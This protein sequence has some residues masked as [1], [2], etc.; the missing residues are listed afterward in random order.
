MKEETI[1]R[2]FFPDLSTLDSEELRFLRENK[3]A[4]QD[5]END[6]RECYPILKQLQEKNSNL[7][8]NVK[9]QQ[10]IQLCELLKDTEVQLDFP[11]M[12][13]N[14]IYSA[15]DNAIRSAEFVALESHKNNLAIYIQRTVADLENGVSQT[16]GLDPILITLLKLLMPDIT[17]QLLYFYRYHYPYHY[18]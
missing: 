9:F 10:I 18:N 13:N 4:L 16:S 11:K 5:A 2:D 15:I 14:G 8:T 7:S 3:K 6:W 17:R 12:L 1:V